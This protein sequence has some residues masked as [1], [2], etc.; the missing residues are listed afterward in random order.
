MQQLLIQKGNVHSEEVPPPAISEN[1]VLVK[2]AYS[3]ISTGTELAGILMSQESVVTRAFKQPHNVKKALKMASEKGFFATYKIIKGMLDFGTPIGYSLAGEVV[4][5]GSAVTDIK[6]GDLVACSGAGVANHAEFVAVPR[7]L[8]TKIPQGL[9]MKQAASVTLGAIAMQGVRQADPRL[10][11]S[12]AVVGLGLIGQLTCQLLNAAGCRVIGIDLDE[13]R[14]KISASLLTNRHAPLSGAKELGATCALLPSELDEIKKITDGF[15]VDTCII[16]ASTESNE[17]LQQAMEITRRKGRV[18]VVGAVGLNLKRSPWY[19]KEIDL[20]I[21]CSYGP[22][23]YDPTYEEDMLDY[24]LPYV[25]WTENR[26]MEEYVKLLHEG[27]VDFL[28]LNPQEF[29]FTEAKN[30]YEHLKAVRPLAVLLKYA[31]EK[32]PDDKKIFVAS[33]KSVKKGRIAVALIGAGAFATTTHLPNLEKLKHLFHL[34]AIVSKKGTTAKQFAQKYKAEYCTTDFEEVLKDPNVDAVLIATRHNLHAK[35]TIAALKAGKAVFLEKPLA[36]NNEE[37]D[38]IKD[39]FQKTKSPPLLMVGFNRRF[40][41]HAQR[42]KELTAKRHNP[43]L[44]HYRVNAGYLAPDHWT[45]QKGG[46]RVIGEACHF[47]DLFQ[48]WTN[49]KPKSV[50][51]QGINPHTKDVLAQDNFFA[52]VS[53]EDGSVANLLYTALGNRDLPKEY[54]EVYCDGKVFILDDFRSVSVKGGGGGIKTLSQNKGHLAELEAFAEGFAKGM[55]SIPLGELFSVTELS[56]EINK[57]VS[58]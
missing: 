18:V 34:K 51:A 27:K 19:E 28:A 12:V 1:E 15:G 48:F 30:A 54:A 4:E 24:P 33:Q 13:K 38:E 39:F 35:L 16:T 43:L 25:R 50:T 56:F 53:Y 29:P 17:P 41:P 26:N 58:N 9:D 2:T 6:K 23:R 22:G 8:V 46:G 14:V 31:H 5:V 10:G 32:K 47:L 3:L 7:L 49:A 42:V 44:I 52:T 11:E 57:Q 45:Q 37:L 21:S 55:A 20:K 40:S 36:L